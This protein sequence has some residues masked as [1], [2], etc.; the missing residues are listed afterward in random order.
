[1][2]AR[3]TTLGKR[4]RGAA[5]SLLAASTDA[6]LVRFAFDSGLCGL[7]TQPLSKC[8][9]DHAAE[10]LSQLQVQIG[11]QEAQMEAATQ[12]LDHARAEAQAAA[13]VEKVEHSQALAAAEEQVKQV[14]QALAAKGEE[15]RALSEALTGAQ[16]ALAAKGD[17]NRELSHALTA[18]QNQASALREEW[19]ERRRR[20]V[21][22]HSTTLQLNTARLQAS[23]R[24][25]VDDV[26]RE[27]QSKCA[28]LQ[29]SC[30][31]GHARQRERADG[32]A[33]RANKAEA[34]VEALMARV[35]A[36]TGPE[37]GPFYEAPVGASGWLDEEKEEE[38]DD[39]D[40]EDY[41]RAQ[42]PGTGAGSGAGAGSVFASGSACDAS[43]TTIQS[44]CG[45]GCG[46]RGC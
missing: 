20:L 2:S 3:C 15:H 5:P 32:E 23:H 12:A 1:M 31:E 10:R 30:Q 27:E 24:Q 18:A 4:K 11:L 19:E 36:L 22:E 16:Q 7:S 38:D 26:R 34:Q 25:Q 46:V 37:A 39:E 13:S 9:Q 29:Q 21:G 28:L 45:C 8:E 44:W 17:A 42:G 43:G 40:D 35:E 14:Q 6:E 33:K 41:S